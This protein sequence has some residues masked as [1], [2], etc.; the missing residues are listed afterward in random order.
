MTAPDLSGCWPLRGWDDRGG[1]ASRRSYEAALDDQAGI[2]K[3]RAVKAL[4]KS[5]DRS[6]LPLIERATKDELAT[7]RIAAL[8]R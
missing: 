5:G 3:A 1:A 8:A 4:G 6:V 7:V 2:V